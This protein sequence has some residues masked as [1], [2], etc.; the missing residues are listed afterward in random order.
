M[1]KRRRPA[2]ASNVKPC[3]VW[4]FVL[5]KAGDFEVIIELRR[6]VA[7]HLARRQYEVLLARASGA[8]GATA[9]ASC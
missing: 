3:R 6:G 7:P 5:D 8:R 2:I 9:Y 1:S 4:G